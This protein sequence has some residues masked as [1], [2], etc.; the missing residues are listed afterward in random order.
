[1]A[2]P[3]KA[4]WLEIIGQAHVRQAL[5]MKPYKRFLLRLIESCGGLA[6]M[7]WKNRFTPQ[8]LMYHRIIDSPYINGLTP[9]EFEKQIAYIAKKFR[10][11][12]VEKLLAEV[13][14]NTI[15]PY[16]MAVTFDDGHHDFYEAAWPI[17]KKYNIP[18]TLYIT[19]GFVSDDLWL[20]PDLL[21]Y[22]ILN[23]TNKQIEILP[24]GKI[25]LLP[26]DLTTSWHILGDHC[27]TLSTPA[28]E[29]FIT[30]LAATVTLSPPKKPVAPFLPVS[31]KQLQD[32][33]NE[34]LD[35]GSHT[36]SHPI[37]K[38][39]STAELDDE[40]TGSATV[41]QNQLSRRPKG[42]C[43]PNGRRIDIDNRVLEQ[44]RQSGYEYGLLARNHSILADS[45][46]LVG[47]ISTHNDFDYFKW[48]VTHHPVEEDQFYFG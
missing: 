19:T 7:R 39:L 27:L 14:S 46:F 13:H 43:Y 44:A 42:I 5:A 32:M 29:Q 26:E 6:L 48:I 30:Q 24:L 22:I 2:G 23:A 34:G 20:W 9:Q 3:V 33:V 36:I 47:R 28:R 10:V 8:I 1:M 11:V 4:L 17:L 31:W 37:L 45:P 15:Q 16:T 21:K 35:I 18:T 41:I 40:L 38:S 25:S 12:P